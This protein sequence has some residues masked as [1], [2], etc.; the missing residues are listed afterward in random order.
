[1]FR[2][3][4]WTPY[5]IVLI[6][7]ALSFVGIG[8][9][10]VRRPHVWIEDLPSAETESAQ[11]RIE[12]GN[13]LMISVW[14]QEQISGEQLVREDGNISVVL[15]GDI[16]VAGLT[17]SK[18]AEKIANSLEG[19]IVRNVRVDVQVVAATPQYVTVF[20]EIEAPGKIE[21]ATHDNLIDIIARSGGFSQ[22]AHEDQIYVIRSKNSGEIQVIRFDF[23]RLTT[24]PN[25]GI[26]FQLHDGDVI[27]VD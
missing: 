17:T 24:C 1:M 16:H 12:P 11:Y 27:I 18:A 20:G 10:A 3:C 5:K 22:F 19:D 15:I 2:F 14:G 7:F 23:N 26:N 8:G 25:A 9:C 6:T 13:R 4:T 21:L